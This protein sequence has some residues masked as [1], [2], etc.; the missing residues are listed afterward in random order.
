MQSDVHL[1]RSLVAEVEKELEGYTSINNSGEY[2]HFHVYPQNL[3]AKK[4]KMMMNIS[5][6]CWYAWMKRKLG[7]RMQKTAFPSISLSAS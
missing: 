5:L 6:M 7:M 2:L 1:Q 4:E 3:P